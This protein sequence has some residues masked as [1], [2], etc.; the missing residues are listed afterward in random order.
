MKEG[1]GKR[2]REKIPCMHSCNTLP[3]SDCT[4]GNA[5]P[6]NHRR[7]R[8]F[9]GVREESAPY[10]CRLGEKIKKPRACR[11]RHTFSP[12]RRFDKSLKEITRERRW[13]FLKS[14]KT[15]CLS[16]F[17]TKRNLQHIHT[18]MIFYKKNV[19][20][21]L[22]KNW[23]KIKMT[24]RYKILRRQNIEKIGNMYEK[25]QSNAKRYIRNWNLDRNTYV[26]MYNSKIVWLLT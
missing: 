4:S 22:I 12:S 17:V 7:P 25:W 19:C 16:A 13:Y 8:F 15:S 21:F 18:W 2:E 24:K 3:W 14:S 20:P 23:K 5:T 6:I 9:H 11:H 26:I 1:A 10:Y